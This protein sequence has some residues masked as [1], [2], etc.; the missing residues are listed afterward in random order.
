MK[1]VSIYLTPLFIV[2]L[3]IESEMG[4]YLEAFLLEIDRIEK[5]Y[6]DMH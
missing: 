1:I 3:Y 2:R 4:A 5:F 6:L